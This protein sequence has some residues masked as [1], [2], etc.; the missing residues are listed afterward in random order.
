[1]Y[2]GSILKNLAVPMQM[3]KGVEVRCKVDGESVEWNGSF[4]LV[5]QPPEHGLE[6][7]RLLKCECSDE[8]LYGL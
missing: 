7:F 6:K 8:G 3:R 2:V 4:I 5:W 1:M